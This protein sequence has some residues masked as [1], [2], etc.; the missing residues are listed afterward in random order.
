MTSSAPNLTGVYAILVTIL[1]FIFGSTVGAVYWAGQMAKGQ[2]NS[3]LQLQRLENSMSSF[4][5]YTQAQLQTLGEKVA[6]IE[7]SQAQSKDSAKVR[8]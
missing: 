1:I 6:R 7:A 8:R 3:E 2:V 4:Q 5:Q